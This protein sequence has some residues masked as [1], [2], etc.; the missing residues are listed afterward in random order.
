ML[1]QAESAC[2]AGIVA[3]ILRGLLGRLG[4]DLLYGQLECGSIGDLEPPVSG[5]LKPVPCNPAAVSLPLFD[6]LS[7]CD[8]PDGGSMREE[9][10]TISF[11][12]VESTYDAGMVGGVVVGRRE[13]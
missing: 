13:K 2:Y 8:A 11:V 12:V 9:G 1:P 5:V 3:N 4:L 6:C 10:F 7:S